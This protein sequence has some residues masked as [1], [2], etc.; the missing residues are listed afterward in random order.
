MPYH[1]DPVIDAEI[2]ATSLEAERHDLALGFPPRKWECPECG[3]THSRGHFMTVGVHRCL[4][5]GY[6][7]DGGMMFLPD[8]GP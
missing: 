5:C 7:G 8:G 2:A 3:H 4:H 1:P 6:V